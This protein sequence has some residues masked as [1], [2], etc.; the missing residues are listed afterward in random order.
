MDNEK[1]LNELSTGWGLSI[2]FEIGNRKILFDTGPEP[3]L[4]KRNAEKLKIDLSEINE[5]VISHPHGD[6]TGGLSLFQQSNREIKVY[7]PSR[8]GLDKFLKR[9][10]LTPINISETTKIGENIYVVGELPSGGWG[11][12]EQAFAIKQGDEIHIFAGCSHPGIDNIV[13]KAIN[14]I[15]RKPGIVMGGFHSPSK[16]TLDR[17]ISFK[18]KK[19]FPMH[20]SGSLAKEYLKLKYPQIYSKGGAGLVLYLK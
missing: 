16:E 2:Y 14:D 20:C 3:T 6:H 7:V 8:S 18:P 15:G 1:I 13:E 10:N 19:V 9:M 4:L 11:L 12:W 17:L 5:I